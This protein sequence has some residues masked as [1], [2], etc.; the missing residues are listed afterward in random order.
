MRCKPHSPIEGDPAHHLGCEVLALVVTGLP[1]AGVGALPRVGGFLGE[2]HE[3]PLDPVVEWDELVDEA[4]RHVQHL[5]HGV[6]LSLIPGCIANS[7][8]FAVTKP[9]KVAELV[10]GDVASAIDGVH[11][12]HAS[13]R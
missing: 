7:D 1:H 3:E 11:D 6:E 4:V 10:F 8:R 13:P 2:P 5:P 9:R 12:L